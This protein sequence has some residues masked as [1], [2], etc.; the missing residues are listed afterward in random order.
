M[1]RDIKP[2]NILLSDTGQIKLGDFGLS[3]ES[4]NGT[5]LSKGIQSYL[6]TPIFVQV[7]RLVIWGGAAPKNLIPCPKSQ[8][9]VF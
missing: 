4:E 1:H 8:N 7:P 6:S 9:G 2:S 5:A 3:K